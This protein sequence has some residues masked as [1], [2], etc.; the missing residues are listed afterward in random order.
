MGSHKLTKE[1]RNII[2]EQ[3]GE[4][5]Y[6]RKPGDNTK[7]V[8]TKIQREL[9][10]VLERIAR[11]RFKCS[12]VYELLQLFISVTFSFDR[13]K[14]ELSSDNADIIEAALRPFLDIDEPNSFIQSFKKATKFGKTYKGEGEIETVILIR[15]GGLIEVLEKEPSG[16]IKKSFSHDR[17]ALLSMTAG[18]T[19]LRDRI[20]Y[21]MKA[22][23]CGSFVECVRMLIDDAMED[24]Y[25]SLKNQNN[26]QGYSSNEYGSVPKQVRNKVEVSILSKVKK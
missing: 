8:S 6:I 20:E 7:I 3:R 17:A 19:P 21:V 10:P 25:I 12:T 9:V 5:E 16:E 23:K 22:N 24:A 18:R 14:S 13:L 15:D 4:E 11:E 1:E 2:A 26:A